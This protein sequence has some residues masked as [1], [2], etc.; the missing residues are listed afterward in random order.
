MTHYITRYAGLSEEEKQEKALNDI[1]DYLGEPKFNE[2][3][4]AF[5][6]TYPVGVKVPTLGQFRFKLSF[7]GVQG[8][9][10]EVW[11]SHIFGERA[12]MT[13]DEPE[14]KFVPLKSSKAEEA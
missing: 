5:R 13:D 11:Y 6:N 10:V 4:S 9:P 12:D 14:M 2:I 3:T 8:Y 1:K 7:V